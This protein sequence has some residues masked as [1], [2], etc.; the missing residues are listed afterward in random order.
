METP[1]ERANDVRLLVLDVDGVL[2]D[3]KLYFTARG[4]EM[5]CFH[6]R[7]GAGIVQV[8]RAGIQVAV[9]SGRS[10]EAVERRMSELGVT[11][12]RQGTDDKLAALRELLDIL[13]LSEQAVACIGDD[14][15]DLPL[16]ETA[17]LAV[18][19][20]DA[21]PSVR[22]RA[23]LI[24]QACGGQ[25]AVREVCDLILESQRRAS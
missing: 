7:D 25:G 22:S 23:H 1:L 4:E 5:K 6:V 17:R 3:G 20:A 11:W 21:H 18:A 13:G 24:T 15:A 10:S 12:V 2:T 14:V 9:I 19:V 8:L 16:L